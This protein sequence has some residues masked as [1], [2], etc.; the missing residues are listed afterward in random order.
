M[1]LV[2]EGGR[3]MKNG[4]NPY[5]VAFGRIP[6]S[7]INR[8]IIIDEIVSAF[9]SENVDSQCFKLT[10]IRGSG[11]T[12][13]MT[14][15]SR[16]L[17][18]TDSWIVVD[19]SSSNNLMVD[20]VATLYDKIG[21][22]SQFIDMNLNL[23]AFGVGVSLS[24]NKPSAS[25]EVAVEKILNSI[26]ENG[27]KLLIT[28]DEISK[29]EENIHFIK[30]F[31]RMIRIEL[32]IY[33]IA[34][35][36]YGKIEE[37]ENTEGLTFFYRAEKCR[38]EPL[39]LMLIMEDYKNKL[40]V[41]GDVAKQMALLTKGYP[42]AYQALGKY[43]WEADAKEIT[44]EVLLKTDAALAEGAYKIIWREL[45]DTEKFYIS[46]I[47]RKDKMEVSELLELTKKQGSDWSRPRKS[48]VE[49]EL[50]ISEQRGTVSFSLPRFYKFIE[51][52]M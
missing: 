1:M 21:F 16:Q 23:T 6:T 30:F 48:L 20:L 7:Y 9:N 50:I 17:A 38:M 24:K 15:I 18:E 26:K 33:F 13:A 10:G 2:M 45:T 5:A 34:A 44:D 4:Y 29:N 36:L 37:L 43:M 49:K 52:L 35:G 42:F 32:P 51:N 19:L 22:L 11:K 47:C 14:A 39:N 40:G 25:I 3:N 31:Q 41:S 8:D 46:F 12:V 28:I 27:K